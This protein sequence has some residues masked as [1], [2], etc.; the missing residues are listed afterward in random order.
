MNGARFTSNIVGIRENSVD[1][2]LHVNLPG[3]ASDDLQGVMIFKEFKGLA[4]GCPH[5]H[6]QYIY[7]KKMYCIHVDFM[8]QC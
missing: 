7:K 4:K 5:S 3:M 1:R 2:V 8:N 6:E